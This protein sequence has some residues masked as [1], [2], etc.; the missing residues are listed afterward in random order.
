MQ[1]QASAQSVVVTDVDTVGADSVAVAPPPPLPSLPWESVCPVQAAPSS[2]ADSIYR[3]EIA[4]DWL[5][6]KGGVPRPVRPGYDSGVLTLVIVS[7]LIVAMGFRRGARLWKSLVNDLSDVRRR[8]N[9]FDERTMGETWVVGAMILQTC[10]Y[11]GLLLYAMIGQMGMLSADAPVFAAVAAMTGVSV[12]LYVFRLCAYWV[13]GYAF[14]DPV[15]R[16]QWIRGFNASQVF[17][18]CM[19]VLPAFVSTFYPQASGA[20]LIVACIA[21]VLAETVFI[22]KGFRIFYHRFESLL[23]FILYFCTLEIIPLILACY[24]A[25]GLYRLVIHST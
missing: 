10:I 17:L 11:T 20:M 25:V 2:P 18:G 19:L 16:L 23:Y 6:G 4:T 12:A 7:F 8:S 22:C 9:A 14:T 15:G 21:Y 1:R 5:T 13:T 3:V 24:G